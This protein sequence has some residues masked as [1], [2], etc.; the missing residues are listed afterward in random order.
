MKQRLLILFMALF[1]FTGAWSANGTLSGNGTAGNPF[2]IADKADWETFA[3][4]INAGPMPVAII[5]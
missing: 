1:V 5:S 4:N 3:K 2:K